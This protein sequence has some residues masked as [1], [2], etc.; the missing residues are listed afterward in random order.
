M[1]NTPALLDKL[2]DWIVAWD[3]T[4]KTSAEFD[5][6]LRAANAKLEGRVDRDELTPKEVETYS[7]LMSLADAR[8][9]F[10]VDKSPDDLNGSTPP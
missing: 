2:H 3:P 7:V 9:F 6:E 10:R 8:G 5:N 1:S 4:G